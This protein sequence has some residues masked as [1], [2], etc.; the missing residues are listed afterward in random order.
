MTP[1]VLRAEALA[2]RRA[3]LGLGEARAALL[4][5]NHRDVEPV[6]EAV[7]QATVRAAYEEP[8]QAPACLSLDEA[9]FHGVVGR[10]VRAI[11]PTTEACDAAIL[12]QA[13]AAAGNVMGRGTF[14][15]VEDS[16]H[17]LNL[18]VVLVGATGKARKGTALKRVLRLARQAD[19]TWALDRVLPGLSSGE[20]LIHAVRDP[21]GMP[22]DKDGD[23]GAAD[24][25]LLVTEEEMASVLRVV[26][27]QGNILSPL[28]RQAWDGGRL[29][30]LTKGSPERATDAHISVIG[31]ITQQELRRELQRTEQANGFANRFLW[32][33]VQRARV[34]PDGGGLAEESANEL[35]EELAVAIRR[36]SGLGRLVFDQ[37]AG[38][39][40]RSVYGE[41]SDGKPGLLGALVGRAEAQVVRIATLYA[42]L[43]GSVWIQVQHLR[44]AL[45]VW[46]Y[47]EESA[48]LIFGG[49]L[50]D[51]AADETL[52]ALTAHP[53]GLTRTAISEIFSRHLSATEIERALQALSAAGKARRQSI[54]TGGRPEE[55]WYAVQ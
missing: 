44:A 54:P 21:R 46:R 32:V 34:L 4:L 48:R 33:L 49:S 3:G 27:R 37:E 26:G 10:I 16:P 25:R 52:E 30:T 43:D 20:G 29:N 14:Y 40:W 22:D 8:P 24:K 19:E 11:S 38:D 28:L 15:Q 6:D 17:H 7:V 41:L 12:F 53:E 9:A 55:R 23:A 18:Y 1:E 13:L 50:G 47:A 42:A 39:I 36:G 51:P 5:Q 45:A 2:V 35:A 31:P